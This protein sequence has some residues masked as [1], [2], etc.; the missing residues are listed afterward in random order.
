MNLLDLALLSA[1][2]LS[3]GRELLGTAFPDCTGAA[4]GWELEG[5]VCCRERSTIVRDECFG[6]LRPQFVSAEFLTSAF[7][8]TNFK[9]GAA[10][11]S[12]N[13]LHCICTSTRQ[14]EDFHET[15][16]QTHLARR[17]TPHL[18]I[19]IHHKLL[20]DPLSEIPQDPFLEI[21]R[22]DGRGCGSVFRCIDE[23]FDCLDLEVDGEGGDV[24]LVGIWDEW[25]AM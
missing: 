25:S 9:D 23:A 22:L 7:L 11:R 12:P 2:S 17:N 19:I 3:R 8:M 14:P 16:K 10:T 20:R 1:E 6:Y 24:V 5:G 21:L 15:D 18:E 4:L 13:H